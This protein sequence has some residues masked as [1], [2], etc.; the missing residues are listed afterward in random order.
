MFKKI[1]SN[2]CKLDNLKQSYYF[3]KL[4]NQL[5]EKCDTVIN[6]TLNTLI[7]DISKTLDPKIS[8]NLDNELVTM[9]L[10]IFEDLRFDKKMANIN[11]RISKLLEMNIDFLQASQQRNTPPGFME[12]EIKKYDK[13]TQIKLKSPNSSPYR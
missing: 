6:D 11:K 10:D 4:F 13:T 3:P 12:D 8:Q 2:S 9:Q 5:E 7:D 1:P